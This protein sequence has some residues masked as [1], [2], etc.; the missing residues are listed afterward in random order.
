MDVQYAHT[1]CKE[2]DDE[3]RHCV[4]SRQALSAKNRWWLLPDQQHFSGLN[5]GVGQETSPRGNGLPGEWGICRE[6]HHQCRLS[7]LG[8]QTELFQA[9]TQ[10]STIDF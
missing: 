1:C 3:N 4:Y 6:L 5:P 9:I 7:I 10:F 2:Y 8:C